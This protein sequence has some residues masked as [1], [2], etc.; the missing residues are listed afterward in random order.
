MKYQQLIFSVVCGLVCA[1][2][3]PVSAQDESGFWGADIALSSAHQAYSSATA[4]MNSIS[5]APYVLVGGWEISASLPWYSIDGNYFANGTLP[6]IL[7]TCNRLL[8]LSE[9]RQQRLIRRSRITPIQLENCQEA[10]DELAAT[11]TSVS[12]V[13]DLGFYTNYGVNLTES[14]SWWGGVG[15]GYTLDNGD[16]EKGLGKGSRDTSLQ[17][18]LGSTINQWQTQFM[19]GYVMVDPTDTTDEVD[20]YAQTSAGVAYEFAD[21]FTLGTDYSFEQSYIVDGEDIK[22]LTIYGDFTLL[23]DWKIHLY[24]SDYADADA[25]EYPDTEF[26]V[27]LFY[28]F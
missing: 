22:I 15:L 26:G 7:D 10:V 1:S 3:L 28:S 18:T 5:F 23:E 2:P 4:D 25:E 9:A 14:G 11:A 24:A 21:W 19:L 12:G 20:S 6:R 27:S 13:G 8:G 17:F 16:Y